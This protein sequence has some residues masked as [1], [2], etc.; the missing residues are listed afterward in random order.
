[1]IRRNFTSNYIQ[2]MTKP[3]WSIAIGNCP[4]VSTCID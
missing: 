4:F 2:R 3:N 1:M